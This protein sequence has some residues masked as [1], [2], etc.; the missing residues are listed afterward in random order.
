[1]S[2]FLFVGGEVQIMPIL[3]LG[4]VQLEAFSCPSAGMMIPPVGEQNPA[5][6]EKNAD[7]RSRFSHG[8][9]LGRSAAP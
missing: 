9:F 8:C 4:P 1:V 3:H 6:I 5:G 7:D 2:F